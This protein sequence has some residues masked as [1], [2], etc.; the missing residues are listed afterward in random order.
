MTFAVEA[1]GKEEAI[2]KARA[3]LQH[4]LDHDIAGRERV[5]WEIER[6]G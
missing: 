1:E 2:E 3:E 6:S 4:E 5:A